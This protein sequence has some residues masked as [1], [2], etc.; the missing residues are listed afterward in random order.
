MAVNCVA[1]FF[2]IWTGAVCMAERHGCSQ[3]SA[4]GRIIIVLAVNEAVDSLCCQIMRQYLVPGF[5]DTPLHQQ[6]SGLLAVQV[7]PRP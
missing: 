5:S 6:L 2:D 3:Q 7:Q 1:L 4:A